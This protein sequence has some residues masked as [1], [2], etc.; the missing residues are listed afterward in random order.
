MGTSWSCRRQDV[1]GHRDAM[2]RAPLPKR[3][4]RIRLTNSVPLCR[5]IF[6][7]PGAVTDP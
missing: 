5:R 7:G 2:P 3:K 6:E 4:L 1:V